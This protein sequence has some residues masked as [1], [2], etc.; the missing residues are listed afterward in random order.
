MTPFFSIIIPTYNRANFLPNAIQSVINQ[1]FQDWELIII[2]D[3]SIDNTKEV[4]FEFNDSR[5]I[6]IYKDNNERSAARNT[7]IENA[8]GDFICFL[9]SDEQYLE[10]HLDEFKQIIIK[11][12][13]KE[14]IYFCNTYEE[15]AGIFNKI[16]NTDALSGNDIEYVVQNMISSNRVCIHSN[17]LVKHKFNEHLRIGEDTELWT[18]ILRE[19]PLIANNKYTVVLT[20]HED[21]T[22]HISN[23]KS[24]TGHLNLIKKIIKYDTENNISYKV[25]KNILSIAYF[26]LAR[27]YEYKRKRLK[28]IL[29]MI[30][31]ILICPNQKMKEKIYII[32]NNIYITRKLIS[33]LK[34]SK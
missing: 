13:Y 23:E 34:K 12:L 10:N 27:H 16:E 19:Y 20:N 24:F 32:M 1:T 22:V 28:L 31:S 11:N 15:K 25:R 2:D 30:N 5:I 3:G 18:R 7:G 21:R 8:K 17:I 14:A 26:N 33:L 6:Y 9:D 4:V 29:A